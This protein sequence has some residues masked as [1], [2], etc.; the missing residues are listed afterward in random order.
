MTTALTYM[1]TGQYY[2]NKGGSLRR[3]LPRGAQAAAEGR[4]YVDYGFHLAPMS[5]R[6][7]RRDPDLIEQHGVPSFKIFMFYG[8]ARP[9]RPVRP[10][11]ARS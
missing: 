4:A 10:T 5:T 9:A 8:V 2:L 7:H 1:R 6:A 11:S 3:L